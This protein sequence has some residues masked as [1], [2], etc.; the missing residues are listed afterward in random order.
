[1]YM[2][3]YMHTLCMS[4]IAIGTITGN[5]VVNYLHVPPADLAHLWI[6]CQPPL[7]LP[8]FPSEVYILFERAPTQC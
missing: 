1:M 8:R 6:V 7:I 4:R 5:E 3:M 2:Y